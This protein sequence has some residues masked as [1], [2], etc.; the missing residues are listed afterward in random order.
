MATLY[1]LEPAPYPTMT[2]DPEGVT[3]VVIGRRLAGA[4]F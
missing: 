3:G 2:E 4:D 1:T